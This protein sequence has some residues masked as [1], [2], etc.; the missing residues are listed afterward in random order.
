[1]IAILNNFSSYELMSVVQYP[2]KNEILKQWKWIA[3]LI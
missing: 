3:W 1:M 2:V